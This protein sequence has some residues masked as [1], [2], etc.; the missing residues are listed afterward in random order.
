[1][2]VET[3][4]RIICYAMKTREDYL[5]CVR[6]FCYFA[7]GEKEISLRDIKKMGREEML[8]LVHQYVR[9][10]WIG[11]EEHVKLLRIL[12]GVRGA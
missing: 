9:E 3:L 5:R 7:R 1:M 6:Y 10:N 8:E 4:F 12:K 2:L 11:H